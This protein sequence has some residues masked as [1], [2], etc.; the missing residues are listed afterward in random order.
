MAAIE[1]LV[2]VLEKLSTFD[3]VVLEC[4]KKKKHRKA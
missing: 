2:E 3:A 1:T 4:W